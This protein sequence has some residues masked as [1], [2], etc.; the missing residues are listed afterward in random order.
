MFSF[1]PKIT[2]LDLAGFSTSYATNMDN[3]FQH[4][5][6]LKTLDLASFDTSSV[7]TMRYMFRYCTALTDLNV[8]SFDTRK[9]TQMPA[10]FANCS[11]LKQLDVSSFDTTN[12]TNM[13]Y[14]F[15]GCKSLT[16]LD[17]DH[18]NTEKTLYMS[19]MFADLDLKELKLP[20]LNNRNS[21]SNTGVFSKSDFIEVIT[22]GKDI[23]MYDYMYLRELPISVDYTAYWYD[24]D[25]VQLSSTSELVAY[26]N[27]N[28]KENTY[29]IG[30]IYTLNFE[31]YGGTTIPSQDILNDPNIAQYWTEPAGSVKENH[32]FLGWY[33]SPEYTEVFDFSKEA[34]RSMTAYAKWIEAYTVEIPATLSLNDDTAITIK[35][36]NRGLEKTLK[37]VLSKTENELSDANEFMLMNEEDPA[38]TCTTQ[39][40]WADTGESETV[41]IVEPT[42]LLGSEVEKTA[43]IDFTLPVNP[44][45]GRYSNTLT[46][47]VTY[48]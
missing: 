8:T 48:N 24:Q 26:H 15:Q 10:I 6:S 29:R 42:Q 9:T 7:V 18:F 46:F 36:T 34:V 43:A 16:S 37:V 23:L 31:T 3:M 33:T 45:A 13:D 1:N 35:G 2:E 12:T 30:Y 4:N 25:N 22:L 11:S 14:M 39:L 32:Q 21:R 38:V 5:Q 27:A 19:Y 47:K 20:N 44:Q 41:L 17:V 28:G 40:T